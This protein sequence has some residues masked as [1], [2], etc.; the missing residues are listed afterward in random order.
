MGKTSKDSFCGV[1]VVGLLSIACLSATHAPTDCNNDRKTI[2][3]IHL[4]LVRWSEAYDVLVVEGD[5][6]PQVGELS[7][8]KARCLSPSIYNSRHT[9]TLN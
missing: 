2:S 1:T 5:F 6:N 3:V 4:P 8:S 7:T 9:D